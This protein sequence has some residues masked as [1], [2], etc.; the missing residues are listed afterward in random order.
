[1]LA[2][3]IAQGPTG[4]GK[5]HDLDG[6]I[7]CSVQSDFG[8]SRTLKTSVERAVDSVK[9][10]GFEEKTLADWPTFQKATATISSDRAHSGTN[11]LAESGDE[12]SVYQDLVG[13]DPSKKYEI[14]AWVSATDGATARAQIAAYDPGT[15]VVTYTVELN[16]TPGWQP[17]AVVTTS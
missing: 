1:M 6:F 12:G 16:P 15:S 4:P 5:C 14:D 10:P 8:L 9:D 13:L 11:S 3:I 17:L 7:L 2:N